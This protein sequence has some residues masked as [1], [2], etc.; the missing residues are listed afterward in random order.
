MYDNALAAPYIALYHTVHSA[1]TFHI[2]SDIL[3]G[4]HLRS[5]RR[6]GQSFQKISFIRFAH[7]NARSVLVRLLQILHCDS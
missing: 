7:L 5:C 2:L 1:A 6:I 3:Y 4:T